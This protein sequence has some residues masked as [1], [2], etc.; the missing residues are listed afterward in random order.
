MKA[1]L[2]LTVGS[3]VLAVGGAAPPD[4]KVVL[5]GTHLCCGQCV[6]AVGQILQKVEGASGT[7]DQ[8]AGTV[9]ITAKDNATAQK[10]L[11]ALAEGGF[12]GTI[13][14][15]DL[16]VKD[17]SGATKGKVKTITLTGVHNCCNQ[18]TTGR[19]SC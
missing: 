1:L 9:T 11:D 17:D 5:S 10:A 4:T 19:V 12:H 16:K 13:D 3:L 15:K 18:C 14:N 2:L 8:A 7:C 6:R